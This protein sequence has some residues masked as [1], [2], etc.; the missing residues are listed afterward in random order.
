MTRKFLIIPLMLAIVIFGHSSLFAGDRTLSVKRLGVQFDCPDG[1]VLGRFQEE[2]WPESMNREGYESPFKNAAVLAEPDQ[3][4]TPS[5]QEFAVKEI[6]VGEIPVIWL[7]RL[8]GKRAKF[9]KSFLREGYEKNIGEHSVYQLP[10]F[11]G[12][13][14]DAAFYYLI[15]IEGGDLLEI[16]AHRL[17]FRGADS[18]SGEPKKTTYDKIIEQLI[19][20]LSFEASP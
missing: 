11:P 15:P 20:T 5:G 13:Y 1:F 9:T 8:S 18:E 7:T 16:A 2:K 17:Y 10:G 19:G 3:L 12:P 14:G 4:K 6:P